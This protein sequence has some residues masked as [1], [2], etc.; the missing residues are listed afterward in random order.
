MRMLGVESQALYFPESAE[1]PEGR[2]HFQLRM[3]LFNFLQLAFGEVAVIGSDQF[4]YWDATDPRTCLAPDGFV[5]FGAPDAVF[6]SWK[7]WERGVP[8]VAVEIVS[9]SDA[10]P[11]AWQEKLEQYRRL[12]VTELVRFDPNTPEQPLRVW[13]RVAE[14]LIERDLRWPSALST[15]LGG[16]WLPVEQAGLGLTL[17]L[18]HDPQGSRLFPTDAELGRAAEQR[19]RELEAALSQRAQREK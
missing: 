8:Q 10:V 3:L 18:S 5:W 15:V 4:V 19:V 2:R 6:G 17:R 11:P 14:G 7:V 1:M 12:G 9:D 13:D 16:Y